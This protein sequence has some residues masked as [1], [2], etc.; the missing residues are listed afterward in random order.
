MGE[1]FGKLPTEVLV[2]PFDE[3]K[4]NMDALRD[5]RELQTRE[6]KEDQSLEGKIRRDREELARQGL[7]PSEVTI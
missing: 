3:F 7:I 6:I 2:L 5:L 4:M 1:A